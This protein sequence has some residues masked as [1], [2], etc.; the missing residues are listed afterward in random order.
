ME[1]PVTLPSSHMNIDRR[2]I[3]DYLLSNPT[4]PFNRNPLTKEELIHNVELKRKIDEYK[5]K[6]FKEKQKQNKIEKEKEEEKKEENKEEN[7][8][9]NN[10]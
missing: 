9:E 4:D 5:N 3:E 8:A 10:N 1:N 2:N 7:K 6:K